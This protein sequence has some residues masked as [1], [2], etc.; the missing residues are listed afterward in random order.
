MTNLYSSLSPPHSQ[1]SPTRYNNNNNNNVHY[2]RYNSLNQYY[3]SV[4]PYERYVN[5]SDG[6]SRADNS[7]YNS[8]SQPTNINLPHGDNERYH[9]RFA[10]YFQSRPGTSYAS[11]QGSNSY[12]GNSWQAQQ[13]SNQSSEEMSHGG[14]LL[15][16]LV[17]QQ[18]YRGS[19]GYG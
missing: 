13:R 12:N 15:G 5:E 18:E 10:G 16:D 1:T 9:S 3:S 2:N 8:Y 6:G 14:L 19:G 11:T 17:K 7:S 4:D